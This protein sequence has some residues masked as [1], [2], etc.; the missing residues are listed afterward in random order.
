[1]K[2]KTLKDPKERERLLQ[3]YGGIFKHSIK[4]AAEMMKK[5]KPKKN[6]AR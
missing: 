6:V 3:I 2:G 1:M 4:E 5:Y